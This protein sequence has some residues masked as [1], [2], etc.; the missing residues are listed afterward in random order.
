LRNKG[1]LR[2]LKTLLNGVLAGNKTHSKWNARI[3]FERT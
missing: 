2:K 3:Q 1:L